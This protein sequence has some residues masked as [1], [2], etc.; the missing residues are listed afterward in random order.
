[1]NTT[2]KDCRL[3]GI[4]DNMEFYR[5]FGTISIQA[6]TSIVPPPDAIQEFMLQTGDLSAEF[7]HSTGSVVNAV[8]KSGSDQ[9]H[10]D[11]WEYIRNDDFN[12]NNYFS[13][14]SGARRPAYHENQYGERSKGR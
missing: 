6:T 3:D 7:G 5:G 8:I 4:D 2:Q 13:K 1:M 12:A 14:Q 9:F 10:G 11:L